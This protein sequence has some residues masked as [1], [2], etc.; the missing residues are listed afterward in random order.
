MSIDYRD[1]TIAMLADSEAALREQITT[2]VDT[3]ADLVFENFLLRRLY[4]RELVE[5]IHGDAALAR[6]RRTLR[7]QRQ[8]PHK[9]AA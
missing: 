3:V 7:E 5:R 9:A 2:L 8:H 6:T 1:L 4:E